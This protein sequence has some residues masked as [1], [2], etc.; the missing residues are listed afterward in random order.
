MEHINKFYITFAGLAIILASC[1]TS[2]NQ[3]QN[4]IIIIVTIA[5]FIG[6]MAYMLDDAQENNYNESE[7]K[8]IDKLDDMNN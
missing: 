6:I 7:N 3:Y 5:I 8:F 1:I 4:A 2:N